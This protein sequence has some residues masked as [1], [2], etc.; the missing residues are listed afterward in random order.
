MNNIAIKLSTWVTK[1][2][3][4]FRILITGMIL[5]LIWGGLYKMTVPGAEGIVPLVS[6]SP[7]ISWHFKVFGIYL[8][9]DLIGLT[10]ITSALLLLIGLFKPGVGILGGTI[11]VVI[12][13]TTSTM[14]ISTPGALTHV[15]G[16]SYLST[17]GLFLFKD[18][19]SLGANFYFIGYFGRKVIKKY[20]N[21]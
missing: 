7:L 15:N 8:G 14:V 5:M 19:I 16:M 12:F 13:F 20:T 6:N 9:A 3:I 2:D 17:L 1:N 18:I 10:E 4:A 21:E 11:G